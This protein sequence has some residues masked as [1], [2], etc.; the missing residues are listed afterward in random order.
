VI[1]RPHLL[2]YSLALP[3]AV[4]AAL[5]Q[6]IWNP[7]DE[8]AH[9]DLI[10]Q[11]AHGVASAV[12]TPM[13]PETVALM[14]VHGVNP[15][16][17]LVMPAQ[18]FVSP[19]VGVSEHAR[20]VW[21]YRHI[22]QYSDESFE[23][24]VYYLAAIPIWL[25]GDAA[26]GPA[27]ALYAVR[28]LNA[29]LLALLAPI[30]FA[31]CR[32][33]LP[34]ARLAPWLAAALAAVMPGSLYNGTHVTNDGLATVWGSG[35]VLFA[36]YRATRGW[37][38]RSSLIAGLLL[39]LLV[40]I[41]PTAGG[42]ALTIV[43]A[44]LIAPTARM[45]T[46]LIHLAL[47][48]AASLAVFLPWLVANRILYGS[49][50]Q[51]REPQAMLTYQLVPQM[52]MDVLQ[53]AQQFLAISFEF[54]G[55][56]LFALLMVAL[57]FLALP[58]IG[59]LLF[60]N[61]GLANRAVLAVCLAGLAGEGA[62][63]LAVP[64]LAG[65]GS[66]SPGRYLYPALAPVF[67]LLVAAWWR[68]SLP[69]V[70]G[71]GLVAA[72]GL[73]LVVSLPGRVDMGAGQPVPRFGH[74]SPSAVAS[75]L[76]GQAAANGFMVEV[77]GASY[78]QATRTLWLHYLAANRSAT[79]SMEWTPDPRLTLDGALIDVPR[80][81][82]GLTGDT[83]APGEAETGWVAL[84]VDRSRLESA[85]SIAVTFPDVADLGYRQLTNVRVPLCYSTR[86]PP[87]GTAC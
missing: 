81:T 40:L 76:R 86:P 58:G 77:D 24:P 25:A 65:S 56:G 68:Y 70:V 15:G 59:R 54:W 38:P 7:I 20:F 44:V 87:S 28:L 26:G 67:A 37:G 22:W 8:A 13:R 6:P 36:A 39:G 48:V 64:L 74:P 71:L 49:I 55:F 60:E 23:P 29:F 9:F 32:L 18:T 34:T 42:I 3:I 2:V 72:A 82:Y 53:Q 10:D 69:Q 21:L 50:T 41:K 1:G 57:S 51:F 61:K 43:A 46:R 31:L 16:V 19:P 78:D 85:R 45:T 73:A 17:Q 27:G 62:L 5:L 12:S 63:A 83:L 52:P 66:P 33:L 79:G 14:R 75:G 84:A 47:V 11:Y 4:A 30:S 35:L 80:T